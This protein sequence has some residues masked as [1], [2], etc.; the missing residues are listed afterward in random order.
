MKAAEIAKEVLE[1]KMSV[2]E[3]VLMKGIL[4]KEEADELLKIEKLL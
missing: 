1:K 3:V 2:K 4:S